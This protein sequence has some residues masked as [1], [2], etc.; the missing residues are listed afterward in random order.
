MHCKIR[1]TQEL[2]HTKICSQV[3]LQKVIIDPDNGLV[4]KQR[5]AFTWVGV[6]QNV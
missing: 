5:Q 4:P 3:Y 2:K 6:S 1:G